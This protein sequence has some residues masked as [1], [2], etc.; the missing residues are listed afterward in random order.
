M[1]SAEFEIFKGSRYR[2][3]VI[4]CIGVPLSLLGLLNLYL[5]F[6]ND[7]VTKDY[8]NFLV[9]FLL[10]LYFLNETSTYY[11]I[12][13]DGSITKYKGF[14]AKEYYFENNEIQKIAIHHNYRW[15]TSSA[16]ILIRENKKEIHRFEFDQE[17]IERFK[18]C[19][20]KHYKERFEYH[21][22]GVQHI[23]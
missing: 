12:Y 6:L 5:D 11:V 8:I 9:P 10:L 20:L 17:T 23:P 3:I 13:E 1:I 2:K 22:N 14:F 19:L 4:L 7:A 16:I 15:G 21:I 18:E